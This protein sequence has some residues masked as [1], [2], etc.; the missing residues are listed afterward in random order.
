MTVTIPLCYTHVTVKRRTDFWFSND[1]D[2]RA[3]GY[4]I[5]RACP[6]HAECPDHLP[7]PEPK[8]KP[9]PKPVLKRDLLNL[10]YLEAQE[11]SAPQK[12]VAKPAPTPKPLPKPQPAP[13][14]KPAPVPIEEWACR[15]GHVGRARIRTDGSRKCL[16]CKKL[17]RIRVQALKP[18]PVP[19]PVVPVEDW[20][21]IWG[22]TGRG[23]TRPNGK[24]YC[25]E[26]A[27]IRAA[28]RYRDNRSTG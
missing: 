24:I 1:P 22:H 11:L 26:C 13:R 9:K 27:R 7:E 14:P 23:T 20:T 3:Q 5:C 19:K 25:R 6:L 15:R 12:P 2:E 10:I 8:P 16:E 18:K 17:N 21:C 28:T 4:A